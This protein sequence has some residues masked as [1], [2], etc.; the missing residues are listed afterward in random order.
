[1][2]HVRPLRPEDHE[3]LADWRRAC[4]PQRVGAWS[5]DVVASKY[6]RNPASARCPESGLYA[7]VVRG[8]ILGVI[9]AYPFPIRW[10]GREV[11]GHALVDGAVL[12]RVRGSAV[13]RKLLQFG[14]SLPGR[15]Y[16]VGGGPGSLPAPASRARAVPMR[17]VIQVRDPLRVLGAKQLGIIGSLAPDASGDRPPESL[18]ADGPDDDGA[19]GVAHTDDDLLHL[20]RDGHLTGVE[21]WT[22][23]APRGLAVV[24][25]R[26][27]GDF[28]ALHLL[29]TRW[30]GGSEVARAFG[31][32]F[33]ER[34]K[35]VSPA[36]VS[37]YDTPRNRAAG[38]V[39][40]RG[41]RKVREETWWV[42]PTDA[43]DGGPPP[44]A[45]YRFEG[46]DSD[47]LWLA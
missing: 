32:W 18:P 38:L 36:Y 30:E 17:R 11:A 20:A 26:R 39:R 16:G 43:D 41:P 12:P 10:Q 28:R 25:R 5:L 34:V 23:D 22:Y 6:W 42:F 46:L 1:V 19:A 2:N 8:E 15:K 27:C 29:H 40:T 33:R 3:L 14:L 31:A 13:D 9:G 45:E 44:D 7:Y 47:Q 21:L 37:A 24:S 35:E 4:R